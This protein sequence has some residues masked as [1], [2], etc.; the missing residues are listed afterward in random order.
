ML[1]SKKQA[2]FRIKFQYH[3]WKTIMLI[4][5]TMTNEKKKNYITAHLGLKIKGKLFYLWLMF[6]E[7]VKKHRQL[8]SFGAF[9]MITQA[10]FFVICMVT[11]IIVLIPN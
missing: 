9:L 5:L 4:L 3:F 1:I 11:L 6:L 2:Y 8:I 7:I 10:Y